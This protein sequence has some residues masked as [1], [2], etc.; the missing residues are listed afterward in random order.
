MITGG[1]LENWPLATP[2]NQGLR[3][4][5]KIPKGGERP[6]QKWINCI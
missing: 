4:S 3:K 1:K 2:E 6:R 5:V